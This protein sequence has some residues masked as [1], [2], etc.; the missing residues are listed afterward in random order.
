MNEHLIAMFRLAG[1]SYQLLVAL[2]R[3]IERF[4]LDRFILAVELFIRWAEE[5]AP[6]PKPTEPQ[7]A[8]HTAHAPFIVTD[9]ELESGQWM[10]RKEAW[11]YLGVVKSTLETMIQSGELPAY[12][13]M[14]DHHKKK[15]RVWLRREDVDEH[16]RIYTLRKG[17]EKKMEQ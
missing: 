2:T 14:G 10:T 8:E 9:E 3:C 16:Y 5:Q 15:S 17:K 4:P 11:N 1:R 12:Q 7:S 6:P 13:K